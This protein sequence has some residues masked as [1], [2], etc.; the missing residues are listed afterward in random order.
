MHYRQ[1][2]EQHYG[3]IPKDENGKSYDIHHIDGNRENNNIENLVAL[4]IADHYAIHELQED[5]GACIAILLRMNRTREEISALAT[6]RNL[7]N[8]AKGTNPFCGGEIQRKTQR[9]LVQDGTHHF[10]GGK[11]QK[12]KIANGTHHFLDKE[13]A[14]QRSKR[15]VSEGKCALANK[16]QVTC[17]HCNKTGDIGN[18]SQ[19]H[20]EYCAKNP[21]KL[22]KEIPIITCTTCGAKAKRSPNF[23]RYHNDN[24]RSSNRK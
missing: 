23:F 15:I 12:E 20:F 10:L 14:R 19:Y 21:N 9:R 6:K 11:I 4:S 17:P 24:C 5:W 22:T 8:A 2:Y 7:A 3:A 18:M 16:K 1:I 13:W